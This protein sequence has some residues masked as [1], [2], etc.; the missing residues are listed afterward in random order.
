MNVKYSLNEKAF[1]ATYQ[2]IFSDVIKKWDLN[3]FTNY[4]FV[5]WNNYY[6]LG[7][8]SKNSDTDNVYNRLRTKE[9]IAQ[10][11]FSNSIGRY[12]KIGLS[13]F[14][15]TVQVLNDA[16]FNKGL[17]SNVVNLYKTRQFAGAEIEYSFLNVNDSLF[18]TKGFGFT[19]NI[20]YTDNVQN[21]NNFVRFE[22]VAQAF[23]P[24]TKTLGL[25]MKAGGASLSGT[26]EFYQY[27]F[28]GGGR[29]LRG[30]RRSRFFGKTT[31]YSQNEIRW[32]KH[33]RSY[34]YNGKFGLM[35]IYDIGRVWM[36]G[37]QSNKWHSGVGGG[38]ILS[39]YNRST[40][41]AGYAISADGGNLFFRLIKIL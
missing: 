19:A 24:F 25:Y 6:G 35:A 11:G 27:N 34:L 23:L 12:Q 13:G 41:S 29:T 1:S 14:Y 36:P 18:P 38:I 40:V 37:E 17:V 20:S 31:A 22:G 10:S 2:G 26:P 15:Q 5:R 21:S 8:E 4:D 7:N 16:A 28:I 39:P 32:A 9:F 3:I 30:Y 33:V